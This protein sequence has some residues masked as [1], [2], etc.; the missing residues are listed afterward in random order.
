MEQAENPTVSEA[1]GT[2]PEGTQSGAL[3]NTAGRAIPRAA[4]NEAQ[5]DRPV[6]TRF[7]ANTRGF[8]IVATVYADSVDKSPSPNQPQPVAVPTVHIAATPTEW[9]AQM[10]L[11]K[12]IQLLREVQD[13][14]AELMQRVDEIQNTQPMFWG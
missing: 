4:M 13:V 5:V 11:S 10:F 1:I 14:L 12:D 7:E 2:R 3:G 9:M 6:R 8:D